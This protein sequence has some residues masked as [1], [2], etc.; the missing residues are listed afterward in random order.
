MRW[1]SG[2]GNRFLL[3]DE[4]DEGSVTRERDGGAMDRR[5]VDGVLRLLRPQSASADARLVITNRDGS[6]AAACGNGLRCVG[7][8]LIDRGEAPARPVRIETDAGERTVELVDRA[9]ETA[10]LRAAMG[11]ASAI[12]L[13]EPVVWAGERLEARGV[14]LGNDHLVLRVDDEREAPVEPLGRRLQTHTTFPDGVNVGFVARRA[15]A[16]RLRVFERGVGETR[17]CGSGACA[18]AWTLFAAREATPP[19]EIVMAGGVLTVDGESP[20]EL[21]CSG[22]A[23]EE[24][25]APQGR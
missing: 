13:A 16:W 6:R 10:L 7:L 8:Y 4:R 15:G 19:V 23:R 20:G 5:D 12:E 1:F 9:E 17:A 22:E 2:A 14:R 24:A 3:I 11:A 25:P 18:A 21:S